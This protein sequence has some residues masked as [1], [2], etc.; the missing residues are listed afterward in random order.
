MEKYYNTTK[1]KNQIWFIVIIAIS[2]LLMFVVK[3]N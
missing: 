2:L 1:G 3:S